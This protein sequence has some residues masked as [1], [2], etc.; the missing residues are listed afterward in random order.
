LHSKAKQIFKD[1]F[2]R[3]DTFT[4][5]VCNGC[6]MLSNLKYLIEEAY[7][8]SGRSSFCGAK[9]WPNFVRNASDSFEARFTMVE[10]KSSPN[11]AVSSVWFNGMAGS[12][13]PIAVAH[14]EGRAMFRGAINRDI[15]ALSYVHTDYPMNPNGSP[16]GVTGVSTL[17]GRVLIMMPHPERVVRTPSLSWYPKN[18][19]TGKALLWEEGNDDYLASPWMQMFLNV[20]KWAEANHQ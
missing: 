10:L 11:N 6:Q 13:M 1:F 16:E 5:G 2:V 19:E 7:A 12:K 14:G 9:D 4:L 8:E 15:V 3:K 18:E 20:K 17:D